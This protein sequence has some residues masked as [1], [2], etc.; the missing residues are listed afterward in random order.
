LKTRQLPGFSPKPTV[1]RPTPSI[2]FY[3]F[4][5]G[6]FTK[7]MIMKE[8]LKLPVLCKFTSEKS[9]PL[10]LDLCLELFDNK[11]F[12]G[13]FSLQFFIVPANLHFN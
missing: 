12:R 5:A 13:I 9:V 4:D 10:K 8:W 6:R 11:F 2:I 1:F 3:T 7:K